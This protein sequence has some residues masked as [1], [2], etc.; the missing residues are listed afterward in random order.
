MPFKLQSVTETF[1]LYIEH[2]LLFFTFCVFF[3]KQGPLG[4]FFI[5]SLSSHEFK[6]IFSVIEKEK[7]KH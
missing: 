4:I 7:D 6:E 2:A 5:F 3:L 1:Y